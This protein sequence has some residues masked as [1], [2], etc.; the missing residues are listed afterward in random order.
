MN[1]LSRMIT[2]GVGDEPVA[3]ENFSTKLLALAIKGFASP[4]PGTRIASIRQPQRPNPARTKRLRGNVAKKT[5]TTKMTAANAVYIPMSRT[6]NDLPYR[7][8]AL[9]PSS[10]AIL[11]ML[12]EDPQSSSRDPRHRACNRCMAAPHQHQAL[13]KSLPACKACTLSLGSLYLQSGG[14]L[15]A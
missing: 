14:V 15:A 7:H 8:G 1:H 10:L 13:P 12:T 3:R 6:I 11:R 4:A 5:T 9:R 2:F